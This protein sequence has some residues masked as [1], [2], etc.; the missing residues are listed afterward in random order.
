MF[1]RYLAALEYPAEGGINIDDPKEFRNIIL[2]LEDQKIRHYTIEDRANLRKTNSAAE[3]DPAYE[4]YKLDLKFPRNLQ[5][6][7]EELTWLFLYAIKLE[8]SDNVDRYRPM[9]AARKLDEEKKATAAPEIKSTN[10]FD[11]IDFT[12]KD[13]EEGSRKLAEKLGVA[14]HPDHLV[15]LR[16]SGRVISTMLNKDVLKEPI[17]TG[18]PFPIDEGIGMGYEKDP[19]LEKAARI[20]RLLQIQSLRKLQTAINETIVSVQNITADPRTDTTL[21]KVGK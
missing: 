10:P 2:W 18:K 11:N 4:K 8:Y 5:S 21:G 6:K 15:S 17:I 14:Y 16:A 20:L 1:E 3:W 7:A 12:S 19:D 13:F 9:T